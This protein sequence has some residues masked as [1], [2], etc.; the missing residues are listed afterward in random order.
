MT[1]A[2]PARKP[3]T[4]AAQMCVV[5]V[6]YQQFALPMAKGLALIELM[7][8]AETV[9]YDHPGQFRVRAERLELELQVIKP[10]QVLPAVPEAAPTIH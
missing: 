5:T 1:V 6:G 3:A 2:K 4:K 9:D 8:T 10:A 7:A